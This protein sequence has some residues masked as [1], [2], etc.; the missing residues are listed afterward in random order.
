MHHSASLMCILQA[1]DALCL[2]RDSV[3]LLTELLAVP[4]LR[5][6]PGFGTVDRWEQSLTNPALASSRVSRLASIASRASS[7]A[8]S[9]S[10]CALNCQ[11][12]VTGTLPTECRIAMIYDKFPELPNSAD[13]AFI[14]E[15]SWIAKHPK[16]W[17]GAH[18]R[19]ASRI[20][21]GVFCLFV[22]PSRWV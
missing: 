14:H 18:G 5:A 10:Q 1:C 16:S 20:V 7:R 21:A 8:H 15:A 13:G 6:H 17:Y 12:F 9:K 19:H 11:F 22:P 4:A 3:Q 2:R